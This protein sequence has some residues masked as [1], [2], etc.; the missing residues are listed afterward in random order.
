MK[1]AV[2][3]THGFEIREVDKPTIGDDEILVKITCCG[4]CSGYLHIYRNRAELVGIEQWLGHEGSGSVVEVGKQVT[5]VD[6]GDIVT[7]LGK[8][9]YAEYFVSKLEDLAILSP[10]IDQ[11][12]ASARPS[13]VVSMRE[14]GLH[15]AWR[16]CRLGGLLVHGSRLSSIGPLP[17]GW[18][19]LRYR[20]T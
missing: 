15:S 3:T 9:A 13:G 20:P 12:Y 4:V 6:I 14:T 7:A 11:L 18:I 5:G 8:P 19:R 1:A 17:E 2:L 16:P 10:E